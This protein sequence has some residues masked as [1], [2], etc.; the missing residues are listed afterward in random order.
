[1]QVYAPRGIYQLVAELVQEEGIGDLHQRFEELKKELASQ[2][3]FD[4]SRKRP[5]PLDAKR[6]AVVTAPSGA[7]V[8]D[9]LTIGAKRG[10]GSRIRIYPSLV[11]GE[12]APD[13]L[14]RAM[15]R[16]TQDAWAEVLVLIRGGGSLEDLWAF[17]TR[18]VAEA[19]FHSPI[20][21]LV[22]VGHEIDVSIADLAADQRASTPSHA[23]QLLWPEKHVLMQTL[24]ETQIGLDQAWSSF[25]KKSAHALAVT[26]RELNLL[27]PAVR[28]ERLQ[29]EWAAEARRL[30]RAVR[31]RIENQCR[32]ID[33]LQSRLKYCLGDAFWDFHKQRMHDLDHGLRRAV[34]SFM[35]GKQA[36]FD[37]LD[38]ALSGLDPLQPLKRG[39]AL[40]YSADGEMATSAR[41]M[42][43]GRDFNLKFHDGRVEARTL[44]VTYDILDE[45]KEK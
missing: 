30:Q 1:V 22:G 20:P 45:K 36:D 43:A 23:A 26:V 25:V 2:G 37:I 29:G 3:Y 19:V 8:R 31:F 14:V 41:H 44:D 33:H 24:D 7:A 6:V 13:H 12:Q 34:K 28:L 17:N 10:T 16:C 38:S 11:Q 32:E 35:Q 39:Y 40:A 18:E 5:L 42:T 4:P 15:N 9:F 21:V 27:S